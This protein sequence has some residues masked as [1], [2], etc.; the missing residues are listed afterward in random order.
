L[1]QF[2]LAYLITARDYPPE[3]RKR[4]RQGEVTFSLEV[5]PDGRVSACYIDASSGHAVLD[6]TTCTLATQRA[7]FD[8]AIDAEGHPTDGFY[9]GRIVWD[10]AK[11]RDTPLPGTITRQ[12][13]V[14][15]QGRVSKCR[16]TKVTGPAARQTRIGPEPCRTLQFDRAY[17]AEEPRKRKVVTEVE[18]IVV[19]EVPPQP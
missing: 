7:R 9:V 12:F 14:D 11:L 19:T 3:A 5:S 16:I 6:S 13:E 18:T 8:P 1:P 4:R 17:E 2:D 10:P 15:A